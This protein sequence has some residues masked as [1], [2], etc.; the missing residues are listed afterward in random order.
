MN[1]TI[2]FNHVEINKKYFYDAKR[3]LRLNLVD[4]NNVV[5]SNKVKNNSETSKCFID[6]GIDEMSSFCIILPQMSGY[7]K[8]F[9][10]GGKSML[11]KTEDDEVVL[12]LNTSKLK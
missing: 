11:F 12:M 10:N 8:Y 3:A 5:I 4:I 2:L 1:K 7:I 9:E 6:Y